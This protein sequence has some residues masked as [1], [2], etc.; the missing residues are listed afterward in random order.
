M[1][2]LISSLAGMALRMFL[3]R[4]ACLVIENTRCLLISILPGKALRTLVES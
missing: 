1:C 2:L 4:E 3:N